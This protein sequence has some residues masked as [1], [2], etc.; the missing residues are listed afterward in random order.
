MNDVYIYLEIYERQHI[1][2]SKSII[3]YRESLSNDTPEYK[4]D[5]IESEYEKKH[6]YY[7]VCINKYATEQKEINN[8]Y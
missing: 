7:V 4:L 5:A 1:L 8:L 2:N 6:P 3:L